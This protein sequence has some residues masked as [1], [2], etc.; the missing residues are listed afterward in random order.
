M[1]DL[2]VLQ[3]ARKITRL[4]LKEADTEFNNIVLKYDGVLAEF[5]KYLSRY[6]DDRKK[7]EDLKVNL[8][9]ISFDL[10]ILIEKYQDYLE[11]SLLKEG[12]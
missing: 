4:R 9:G 10:E 8:M 2:E 12:E 3:L 1:R 11:K 7:L 6:L 5:D